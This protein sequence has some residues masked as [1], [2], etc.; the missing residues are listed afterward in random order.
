M[1]R[2]SCTETKGRDVTSLGQQGFQK[3][4]DVAKLRLAQSDPT[5]RLESVSQNV[6]DVFDESTHGIHREC[7]KIY[8][9]LFCE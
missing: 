5:Y 3:I 7:Y 4:K 9:Y 2:T 6:P 8:K 1:Y